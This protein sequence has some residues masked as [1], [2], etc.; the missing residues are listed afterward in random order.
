VTFPLGLR[1]RGRRVVVAGGG[2]MAQ[3]WVDGLLA[4]GADVVVVAPVLSAALAGLAAR[5]L[6]AARARAATAADTDGAWLVLAC[7]DEAAENAAIAGQAEQQ[8][9]WCV[10][11]DDEEGSAI[12]M[13]G[14]DQPA[15]QPADQPVSAVT[16]AEASD[17]VSRPGRRVLVLGG[18]R[19]GKS[20]AAESM[21]ADLSTVEYVAT[22]HPRGSGD[23]EWDQRVRAH[24]ERRPAGWRTVETLDVA[25]ILGEPDPGPPVLV[26]CISTWLARVMDDCGLWTG[27]EDAD[28]E[29]GCRT[30]RLVEAWRQTRRRAVAVSNEV[31]CGIVPAT[32]SG[33]RFR[34][35]L[36]WLNSRIAAASDEVWLCTAGIAQRLR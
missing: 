28:A 34:D 10:R 20:A 17:L 8:R 11:A 1:L 33:R 27:R 22:G 5:G 9:I 6:L 14:P 25:R 31:G 13:P 36:G 4:A 32:P 26:D 3:R 15:D 7:A 35:E 30:D 12:L 24:Q 18:A 16:A 19:S 29:L 2:A 23:T 21:L